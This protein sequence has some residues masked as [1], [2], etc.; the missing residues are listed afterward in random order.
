[1]VWNTSWLWLCVCVSADFLPCS[2]SY[3]SIWM[4][5]ISHI[6]DCRSDYSHTSPMHVSYW[7]IR[8]LLFQTFPVTACSTSQLKRSFHM[9][10]LRSFHFL[11]CLLSISPVYTVNQGC[12]YQGVYTYIIQELL[13]CCCLLDQICSGDTPSVNKPLTD[14]TCL[15]CVGAVQEYKY[16]IKYLA[17]QNKLYSILHWELGE[18]L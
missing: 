9:S 7:W 4:R 12:F 18:Y 13:F 8:C 2:W 11:L 3:S 15:I 14:R 6:R 10:L 1:M 17:L 5:F 16:S